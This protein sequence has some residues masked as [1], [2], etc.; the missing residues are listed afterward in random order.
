M[1]ASFV[2]TGKAEGPSQMNHASGSRE[3]KLVMWPIFP[4][5]LGGGGDGDGDHAQEDDSL[6]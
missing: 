1:L 6:D 5:P 2:D 3:R 4:R